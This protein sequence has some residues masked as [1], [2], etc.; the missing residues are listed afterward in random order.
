MIR[1]LPTAVCGWRAVAVESY[2]APAKADP[3]ASI[4]SR[5]YPFLHYK[6]GRDGV[7]MPRMGYQRGPYKRYGYGLC[8]ASRKFVF[9]TKH[10][11]ASPVR[12]TK[13][14][15]SPLCCS[16]EGGGGRPPPL[17]NIAPP[18][19]S[20][21][22]RTRT[23]RTLPSAVCAGHP[24]AVETRAAPA[25]ANPHTSISS[26]FGC[27]NRAKPPPR[28]CPP[29]PGFVSHPSLLLGGNWFLRARRVCPREGRGTTRNSNR[30][31]RRVCP[32]ERR[33]IGVLSEVFESALFVICMAESLLNRTHGAFQP[34]V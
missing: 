13:S 1:T 5:L 6:R 8:C 23:N 12:A 4:S 31:L 7:E 17:S 33:N 20:D 22:P 29:R 14:A 10:R 18:R 2:A 24:V 9:T 26:R 27:H 32:G 3:H 19:L 15:A 21:I 16:E 30:V 34:V 28:A 25:K 11:R